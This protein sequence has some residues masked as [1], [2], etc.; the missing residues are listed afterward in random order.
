MEQIKFE[1]S[2]SIES[3]KMAQD[4]IIVKAKYLF[5]A[6]L[7]YVQ[8]KDYKGV[9]RKYASFNRYR[10]I[11]LFLKFLNVIMNTHLDGCS[12]FLSHC[13]IHPGIIFPVVGNNAE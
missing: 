7:Y 12:H 4:I 8:I 3:K 2:F 1:G 6:S 5:I 11:I 9:R 10:M 13:G